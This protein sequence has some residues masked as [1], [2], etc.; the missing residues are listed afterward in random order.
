MTLMFQSRT[1]RHNGVQ[2]HDDDDGWVDGKIAFSNKHETTEEI[3]G[4]FSTRIRDLKRSVHS[5]EKPWG[6]RS[7]SCAWERASD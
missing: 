3:W 5:P 1:M 2:T 4:L 7:D 6:T